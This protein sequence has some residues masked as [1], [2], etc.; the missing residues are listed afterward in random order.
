MSVTDFT[1][2]INQLLPEPHAGLLNGILFGV[3]ATLSKDLYDALIS[4][5]TLHIIAL[6][7][8]NITILADLVS[9]TLLRFVSRR[10]ASLLTIVIIIGFI[11]FVGISPSV[12]RAGI[13]G[14]IT[15]LAV[16]F[17]RQTWALLS[18]LLAVSVMLIISPSWIADV[19]FQ[20]SVLATLGIILFGGRISKASELF[21]SAAHAGASRG[22]SFAAHPS[23]PMSFSRRRE[24]IVGSSI[25][26]RMT[27]SAKGMTV[28]ETTPLAAPSSQN[29]FGSPRLYLHFFYSLIAD[30][31]RITLAAQ[32]FT[33]PVLLVGFH[34]ISL[35][36]PLS[37]I[38]IGWIIQPLTV[39]GLI[40]VIA[41]WVWLP[42]GQVFA[43][44]TWVPLQYV[45]TAISF[46]SMIP[47]TSIA[48]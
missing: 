19:G 38:L 32:V 37:N 30:D 40:T 21:F 43:W 8:M 11:L 23:S 45:L 22:V 7:G 42:L 39:L 48:W 25:E 10:I 36:S 12:I 20:L 26:P 28:L 44:I 6:S 46:T 13:M 34:R 33:I 27:G 29:F 35:I 15:L 31:L 14:S 18:L 47:F 24:S 2:I 5:G 9:L 41:G 3:K 16:I 17:G 1:A 4:T